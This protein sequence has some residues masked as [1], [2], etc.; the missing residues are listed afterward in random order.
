M[1]L[2]KFP[3]IWLGIG[4]IAGAALIVVH[5][6]HTIY[7][8]RG[9]QGGS[10]ETSPVEAGGATGGGGR[11]SVAAG[12]RDYGGAGGFGGGVWRISRTRWNRRGGW[13][14]EIIR[15]R[16]TRRDVMF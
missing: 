3:L 5:D 12:V 2:V 11:G 9:Q 16:G 4:V 15:R 1:L 7:R 13:H 14:F 6:F 10:A 8:L